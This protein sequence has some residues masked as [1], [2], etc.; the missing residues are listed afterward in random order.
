MINGIE[1]LASMPTQP[2]RHLAILRC[3]WVF[4][5]HSWPQVPKTIGWRQL[6]VC[7]WWVFGWQRCHV[8]AF[9]RAVNRRNCSPPRNPKRTLTWP[10]DGVHNGGHGKGRWFPSMS[11]AG[12]LSAFETCYR[13]KNMYP[14]VTKC[15]TCSLQTPRLP[16]SDLAYPVTCSNPC[17]GLGFFTFQNLKPKNPKSLNLNL[18]P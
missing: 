15:K 12:T 1:A 6:R 9:F 4:C 14:S 7:F 3:R 10:C 5:W 11:A 13:K 18:K 2:I 8:W 17:V 16:A